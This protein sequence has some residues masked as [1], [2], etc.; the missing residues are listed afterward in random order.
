ME[1]AIEE[2]KTERIGVEF[3]KRSV[4]WEDYG[5][6]S[7]TNTARKEHQVDLTCRQPRNNGQ[8]FCHWPVQLKL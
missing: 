3:N 1:D 5:R 4:K 8:N 7:M 2:S 6:N